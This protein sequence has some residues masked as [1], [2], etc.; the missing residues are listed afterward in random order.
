M[1]QKGSKFHEGEGVGRGRDFTLWAKVPGVVF[2][3]T[4][5]FR[6]RKYV[7]VIDQD[8]FNELMKI[9]VLDV[10]RRSPSERSK[11]WPFIINMSKEKEKEKQLKATQK[12]QQE[13]KTQ[14]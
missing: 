13:Q 14:Q 2:I 12:Q 4:D 6:D 9:R 1:R 10:A 3:N 8:R 7:H 5:R 11:I